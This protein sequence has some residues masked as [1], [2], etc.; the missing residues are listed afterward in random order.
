LR[1]AGSG[2]ELLAGLLAR[3]IPE[4]RVASAAYSAL[5]LGVLGAGLWQLYRRRIVIRI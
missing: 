3:L 1:N 4:A 2:H 5:L